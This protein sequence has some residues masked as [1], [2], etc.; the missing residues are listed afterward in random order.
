MWKVQLFKVTTSKMRRKS[1][2]YMTLQLQYSA[3]GPSE[4]TLQMFCLLNPQMN[5]CEPNPKT[6]SSNFNR[7]ESLTKKFCTYVISKDIC[8]LF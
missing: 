2:R 5:V 3:A 6:A 8:V 7:L 1:A 4:P